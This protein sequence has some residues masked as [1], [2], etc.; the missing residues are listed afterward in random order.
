MAKF[1]E[2]F[3]GSLITSTAPNLNHAPEILSPTT[4]GFNCVLAVASR[5]VWVPPC[6]R[7]HRPFGVPMASK[8]QFY[9]LFDLKSNPG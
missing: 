9:C 5:S 4:L 7:L 1:S 3:K 8:K 6:L 2:I